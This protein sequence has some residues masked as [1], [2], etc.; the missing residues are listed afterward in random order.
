[1][2]DISEHQH[3][4]IVEAIK[5][6]E[7]GVADLER[8][9]GLRPG[10]SRRVNAIA[11]VVVHALNEYACEWSPNWTDQEDYRLQTQAAIRDLKHNHELVRHLISRA[12]PTCRDPESS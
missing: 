11:H 7:V 9:Q 10:P 1:M 6:A 2:M 4:V 3:A 8:A 5:V 12:M